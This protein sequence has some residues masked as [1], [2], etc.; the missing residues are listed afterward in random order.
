LKLSIIISYYNEEQTIKGLL[1]E[2]FNVKFQ[3]KKE[4]IVVYDGVI[5]DQVEILEDE[6]MTN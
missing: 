6:I 1:K 3:I 4:V 5:K 2:L